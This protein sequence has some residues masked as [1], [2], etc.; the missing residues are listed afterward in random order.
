M[1]CVTFMWVSPR[2][3]AVSTRWLRLQIRSSNIKFPI[4]P[5]TNAVQRE[6]VSLSSCTYSPMLYMW[7]SSLHRA[8]CLYNKSSGP[9]Q[10]R[11]SH[12]SQVPQQRRGGPGL[13]EQGP[14]GGR[15]CATGHQGKLLLEKEVCRCTNTTCFREVGWR[16]R[17]VG[18]CWGQ[19]RS[20]CPQVCKKTEIISSR[21]R[22]LHNGDLNIKISSGCSFILCTRYIIC[23][24]NHTCKTITDSV[25]VWQ[26]TSGRVCGFQRWGFMLCSWGRFV[27]SR[28]FL[29]E[30]WCIFI[31]LPLS[32]LHG[33]PYLPCGRGTKARWVC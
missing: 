6:F 17:Y 1:V 21:L 32:C 7:F 2:I 3:T 30:I 27:S 20:S 12:F 29:F 15:Q 8:L 13:P 14:A 23:L 9:S 33:D 10:P 26:I 24:V 16:D 5:A 31:F 4:L 25:M 19:E 11:L 28:G 18:G 22:V